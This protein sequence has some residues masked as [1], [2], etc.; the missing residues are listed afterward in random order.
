M[1]ATPIPAPNLHDISRRRL[2]TGFSAAGGLLVS[3]AFPAAALAHDD[4][5]GEDHGCPAGGLCGPT[6]IPVPHVTPLPPGVGT[7][8]KFHFFF[9]GPVEGTLAPTDPTGTH[10]GGRDPST[11][12]DF[13]GFIGSCDL[14]L[15]GMGT[16]LKTGESRPYGFHTDMR[17]MRGVFLGTDGRQHRATLAFI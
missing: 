13:K 10:P 8:G 16:N 1:K 2:L 17:F 5:Q 14:D 3:S 9:P 6:P 7:F 15:T 11:I 4:D 12:Y